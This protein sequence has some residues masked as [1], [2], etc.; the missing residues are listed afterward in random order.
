MS[1]DEHLH[2]GF[3][4]IFPDLMLVSLEMVWQRWLRAEAKNENH[5]APG[6]CAE[7]GKDVHAAAS[8]VLSVQ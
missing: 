6:V 3:S 2:G 5:I 4:S 1:L 7:P 8:L